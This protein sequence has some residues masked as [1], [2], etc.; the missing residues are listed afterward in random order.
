MSVP[1]L[2]EFVTSSPTTI[3]EG[4]SE[5]W[6]ANS[7]CFQTFVEA[8][9]KCRPDQEQDLGQSYSYFMRQ[10]PSAGEKTRGNILMTL[11]SM[12]D[13]LNRQLA[14]E[15]LCGDTTVTPEDM[16]RGKIIVLGVP[17][18][19]YGITGR[20]I[21]GI[22][23]YSF[24]RAMLRRNIQ[25]NPRAVFFWAD[26]AQYFVNSYDVQFLSTCR[27]FRV[28]NVYLTQN[29]SGM[30]AALG[31]LHKGKAECDAILACLN[32]KILHANG[33]PVTNEWAS[34]SIGQTRQLY[35]SA[36]NS[37]QPSEALSSILGLGPG[38]QTSAGVAE[39]LDYEV[40]PSFFTRL[41][42]GGPQNDWNV[43]AI[44]FQSGRVFSD[45]GR[46]WRH[47]TFRQKK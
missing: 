8:E 37:Y 46:T 7:F 28:A 25:K 42:T 32:S 11:T 47:A 41:R 27:S 17:I 14:R 16:E 19:E 1:D 43:D 40:A 30:Y 3:D 15:L 18:G 36:N 2:Y 22:M 23:R 34:T 9:R 38:P 26:E 21:Q 44:V 33:C 13:V 10:L 39:H 45:T 29:L 24:Q 35:Y 5:R 4:Q 12:A 6:K 20:L 31:G